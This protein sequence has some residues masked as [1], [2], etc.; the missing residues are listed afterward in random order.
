LLRGAL[1]VELLAVMAI[2]LKSG[3]RGI[4]LGGENAH[5]SKVLVVQLVV[6]E[7]TMV[8]EKRRKAN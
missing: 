1:G 5:F 8:S 4:G 3:C 7:K 6:K 2:L